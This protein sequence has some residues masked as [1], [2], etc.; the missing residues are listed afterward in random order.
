MIHFRMRAISSVKFLSHFF[1]LSDLV[2]CQFTLLFITNCRSLLFRK[3]FS[4]RK[5]FSL[6]KRM[7]H[8]NIKILY[9]VWCFHGCMCMGVFMCVYVCM[10][11]CICV[12][13]YRV[14]EHL[15]I[16]WIQGNLEVQFSTNNNLFLNVWIIFRNFS[17]HELWWSSSRCTE[18]YK[19]SFL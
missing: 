11:A 1:L 17:Y 18:N 10:R 15:Q 5:I 4:L 8:L 3:F 6:R 7:N 16:L 2:H 9:K 14:K 13:V 12:C 19:R